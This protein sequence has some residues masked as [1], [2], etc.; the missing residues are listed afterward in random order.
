MMSFITSSRER[1]LWIWLLIVLAGIYATLGLAGTIAIQLEERLL[2]H[3]FFW[4]F[5]LLV[6]ALLGL[7]VQRKFSNKQ[8][9]II[10]AIVAVYG[11]VFLR[12]GANPAERTHIIEYSVVGILVYMI[13]L[14]RKANGRKLWS[15]AIVAIV[16]TAALG[17]VDE[18]IQYFIPNRVFDWIDVGF[19]AFA[20]FLGVSTK[21]TLNWGA[22]KITDFRRS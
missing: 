10:I 13:L 1:K 16:I 20:G 11:M 17:L 6:I 18:S 5:I 8:I 3:I 2:N 15:P 4:V 14:E 19:N 12:M 7:A 22:R 21:A 9:W